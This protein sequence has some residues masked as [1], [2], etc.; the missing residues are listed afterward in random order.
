MGVFDDLDMQRP[1]EPEAPA[2]VAGVFSDLDPQA[3]PPTPNQPFGELKPSPPPSW[4]D[5]LGQKGQDALIAMGMKPY[6]AGHIAH[7]VRDAA[8][9]VPP[10]GATVGLADV[11]HYAGQGDFKNAA[12]NAINA[13]PAGPIGRAA[14]AEVA[15]AGNKIPLN[16]AEDVTRNFQASPSGQ[17]L[18]ETAGTGFDAYRASPQTYS[19]DSIAQLITDMRKGLSS[20]GNSQVA[21][22]VTHDALDTLLAKTK[23][24]PYITPTDIDELR[25]ATSV[26]S[27]KGESGAMQARS[28]LYDHLDKTGDT[29]MR[30]AV[31]NYAAYKRGDLIDEVLTKAARRDDEGKAL[32]SQARSKLESVEKRPRGFNAEEIAALDAAQ[33]GSP[34]VRA[35]EGAGGAARGL[36]GV[37]QG[38]GTGGAIGLHLGGPVGGAIGATLGSVAIPSAAW[39]LRKGATGLRRGAMEDVGDLVRSRSP[40]YEAAEATQVTNPTTP[41]HSA[42]L[43]NAIVQQLLAREQD[44]AF[45]QQISPYGLPTFG[46]Q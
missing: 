10:I 2:P 18:K 38:A 28:M 8:M 40:M 31:G 20:S 11:Q 17:Q 25:Q 4:H 36:Q 23:T 24:Q 32:A 1:Q 9:L 43:R 12:F 21:A 45:Q 44:P 22:P 33:T 37:V 30:D 46:G 34:A 5:W 27:G 39:A 26:A 42:A 6:D 7:G 41:G 13:I 15:A 29:T 3:P 14:T 16:F 19:R 35:L